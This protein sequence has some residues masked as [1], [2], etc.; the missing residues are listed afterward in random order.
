MSSLLNNV[1]MS[2][3]ELLA[4]VARASY[5]NSTMAVFFHTA[6]AEQIGLGATETKTLF[7]LRSQGAL[8][9]GEIAQQTGLTTAS[10]TNLLDRLERKGFVRRVRDTA[11][12][13]R[14]IVEPVETRQA[15][16]DTLFGAVQAAFGDLLESYSDEQLATIADFLRRATQYSRVLITQLAATTEPPRDPPVTPGTDAP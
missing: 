12:R 10:V 11:D 14:V 15:E 13:R 5:E 7:L 1:N 2:R 4:A 9:A 8:T 6:L 16:L 3:L